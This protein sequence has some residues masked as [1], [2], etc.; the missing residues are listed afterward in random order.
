[1]D[2]SPGPGSYEPSPGKS[3][4]RNFVQTSARMDNRQSDVPGPGSYESKSPF[5]K[6]GPAYSM[7]KKSS[8][9]QNE[10]SPGPGN[11]EPHNRYIKDKSPAFSFGS[12][13][14]PAGPS[15]VPGPG[16]YDSRPHTATGGTIGVRREQAIQNSPGPGA[17]NSPEKK[18][19]PGFSMGKGM[20]RTGLSRSHNTLPGPGAYDKDYST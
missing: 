14:M 18:S 1:M 17:Y 20:S 7:R 4:K 5:N 9:K 13:L 16:S 6:T 12:K 3:I 15:N 8:R 10:T 19:G 2:N 11:Y